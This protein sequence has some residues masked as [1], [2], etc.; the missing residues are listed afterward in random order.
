M[1]LFEQIRR[2]YTHGVGTIQGVAKKLGVHRR[3]VRQ[4]L[5][6]AVPPERK[7]PVRR[8]PQL[9]PVMEFIDAILQADQ[10]APRKQRHTAQ[11][12]W[13]RI[14]QERPGARC[15]PNRRCGAM[16]GSDARSWARQRGR[17][18]CRR[19]TSGAA[20]RRL[21]GTT[22]RS[23]WA[24]RRRQGP[25]L[26]DALDGQRRSLSCGLLSRHAAGIPGSP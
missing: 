25:H 14:R 6:S 1:E 9:G 11:R 10:R 12:I 8:Q 24:A 26:R 18:S 4:A 3:M 23:R 16:C 17:R 7:P 15:R 20:K 13:Q 21:I 5:A 22:P 19:S 2:E